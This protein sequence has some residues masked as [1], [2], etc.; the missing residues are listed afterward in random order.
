LHV[1]RAGGDGGDIGMYAEERTQKQRNIFLAFAFILI[2]ILAEC[3]FSLLFIVII[4]IIV[5]MATAGRNV[6]RNAVGIVVYVCTYFV[7][8]VMVVQLVA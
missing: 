1:V 4:I 6:K 8:C 7:W 2:L 5:V 3:F